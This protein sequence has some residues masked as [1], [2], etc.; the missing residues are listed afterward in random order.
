MQ[1]FEYEWVCDNCKK[2]FATKAGSD[3]SFCPYCGSR[4]I[5]LTGWTMTFP[6]IG[7]EEKIA[8]HTVAE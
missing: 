6:I 3:V 1:F 5:H 4:E 7:G 8:S 2:D